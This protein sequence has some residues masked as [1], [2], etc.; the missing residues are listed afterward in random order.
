VHTQDV[1]MGLSLREQIE[2]FDQAGIEPRFGEYWADRLEEWLAAVLPRGAAERYED[3]GSAESGPIGGPRA[4]E[5]VLEWTERYRAGVQACCFP[6]DKLSAEYLRSAPGRSE[7]DVL[8]LLRLFLFEES[9]FGGDA[10][11]AHRV[12]FEDKDRAASQRLPAEYRARL[13][14]WVFGGVK[15]YPSI[16]WVLDLL[17]HWPQRAIDAITGYLRAY[18]QLLPEPRSQGLFDAIAVIRARWIEDLSTGTEALFQLSPRDLELLAAALYRSLGY[19]V[20]VT[21]PSRDGGRD[22]IATRQA[23]GQ[24]EIVNI[25]CKTHTSPIGVGYVRQLRGVIERH[26]VNRGVLVTI[27]TFTR[28]ARMECNSDSRLELLDG[29]ALIQ[30]LNANF[31]PNWIEKRDGICYGLT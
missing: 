31:G 14:P 25:E 24:C 3:I 4:D 19:T 2:R 18:E 26:G 10:D 27:G 28:G 23:A 30:L 22:V 5:T 13:L 11:L 8:A 1:D 29:A 16:R 12:L 9:G 20:Q 15:P 7:A 21:P 17:P 6:T